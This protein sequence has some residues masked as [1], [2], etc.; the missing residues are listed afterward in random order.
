MKLIES[1]LIFSDP[2]G[3]LADLRALRVI[4]KVCQKTK[5]DKIIINGDICD[6]PYISKHAKKLYSDGIMKGYTEAKE[7]EYTRDQ[8]L[9]PLRASNGSKTEI[10][11]RLGNHDERITNPYSLSK[12]QLKSIA[13]LQKHFNT[14]KYDE[15][16][17]LSTIG[18]SYDPSVVLTLHN[19]FDIVHGLS[20]AKNAPEQNIKEYMS[21]G[22]S[23]HSHR[24]GHKYVTNRHAPYVWIES[25]HTRLPFNVEYLPTGKMADWQ[26]GFVTV[27][28]YE[29]GKNPIFFAESHFIY[30]GTCQFNGDIYKA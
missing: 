23:G 30:D 29:N 12:G 11:A 27:D 6:F 21:S 1:V 20:L 26:Q 10:I 4:N 14:S 5:F 3:W 15:M 13:I 8:I 28:F 7:I 17:D 22:S 2:H 16:L 9:K 25:G 19:T 24:L 18:V